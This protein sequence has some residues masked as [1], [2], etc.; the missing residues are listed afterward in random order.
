MGDEARVFLGEEEAKALAA[1]SQKVRKMAWDKDA[2]YRK[3]DHVARIR[4][5]DGKKF[6]VTGTG[7][8]K[9]KV[10]DDNAEQTLRNMKYEAW[11]EIRRQYCTVYR[12]NDEEYYM[13]KII[14]IG[15]SIE[16]EAD[17]REEVVK[18]AERLGFSEDRLEW[19]SLM[20]IIPHNLI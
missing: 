19:L 20:E 9:V 12:Y 14:P 10:E 16:I 7:M 2:Y 17:N 4:Y 5:M 15:W 3:D 1:R 11:F 8:D 13:E 18:K 6:I